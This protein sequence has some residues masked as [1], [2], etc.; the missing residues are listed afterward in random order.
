MFLTDLTQVT[1]QKT[2]RYVTYSPRVTSF[3][4][5]STV[6]SLGLNLTVMSLDITPVP[7]SHTT[8]LLNSH[9]QNEMVLLFQR[10]LWFMNKS[11]DFTKGYG[12]VISQ[13]TLTNQE[14]YV[15]LHKISILHCFSGITTSIKHQL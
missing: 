4:V 7:S 3:G 11:H 2:K 9:D 8:I 15:S 6:T 13:R 1:F 12:R 5:N 14:M 10:T